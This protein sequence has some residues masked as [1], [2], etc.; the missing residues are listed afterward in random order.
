MS[1]NFILNHKLGGS[2]YLSLVLSTQ[3][4]PFYLTLRVA[5]ASTWNTDLKL[6]SIQCKSKEIPVGLYKFSNRIIL[7]SI[8]EICFH[9]ERKMNL[10]WLSFFIWLDET[11][12]KLRCL[13]KIMRFRVRK[14]YRISF[15]WEASR[16]NNI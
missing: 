13:Y 9:F 10:R 5:W 15:P 6:F 11:K 3:F 7:L 16:M 12:V 8:E 14:Q 2:I 4:W 1:Y